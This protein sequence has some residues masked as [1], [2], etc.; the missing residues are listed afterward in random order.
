VSRVGVT[1][2]TGFLGW[3]LVRALCQ[4]GAE[5]KCL[6]RP[7]SGAPGLEQHGCRVVAGDLDDGQ[8]LA[9][10]SADVEVLYHVAGLV[11]A[12]SESEYLRVNR[13]GTLNVVRAA[14][15]AGVSRLIYVSS[16]AVTGPA[17]PGCPVDE[18]RSPRPLTPYGR[19][20]LAGEQAVREGGVPF[21]I[22]RPPAVYGP[23]DR[24]MLRLFRLARWGLVPLL[25]DGRQELSLVHAGDVARALLSAAASPAARGGTYHAAHPGVVSQ[26]ELAGAIAAAVGRKVRLVG[27]PPALI[28]ALLYVSAAGA[29]AVGKVS[30]LSPDKA[31]ELLAPAWTCVSTALERHTGWRALI[32]LPEGLADTARWYRE[33]GWL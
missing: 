18:A 25:G 17:L 21:T 2:A 14:H 22:L 30:L 27:L 9:A 32:P 28:R 15:A 10:L 7:A 1:G 23:R 20:K 13:S 19:S 24:Q 16:L 5:V 3:H 8:A 12:S 31:P 33:V 6:V 26:R 4:A 29:R 11:A